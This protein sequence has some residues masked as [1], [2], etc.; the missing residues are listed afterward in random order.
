MEKRSLK[1]RKNCSN[2]IG[3]FFAL[4][5]SGLWENSVRLSAFGK[6]DYTEVLSL[7]EGQSVVGLVMAGL[8]HVNDVTVPQV[9][10]LLFIGKSVNIEQQ[11]EAM[12]QFVW[13]LVVKMRKADIYTVLVKGQGIAQCYERPLWRACG[14]VYFLLSEDNYEKAKHILLPIATNVGKEYEYNQ[15]QALTTGAYTVEL[16]GNMRCGLSGR[17]DAVIDEVQR[18]VFFGGNVRSWDNGKTYVFLPGIDC[19]VIFVFTHFLKHFYKGGLGLRQICDWCRLLW[20]YREAINR[21]LLESRLREMRLVS[22]WKAFGAFAVEYLGMPVE[23]M[24]L[25]DA[26]KRWKQKAKRIEDFVMMSG[27]F[28]HNRD[29]SYWT[30]YSYLIRKAFSMKRRVGDLI[31]HASIFPMDSL[32]F[33]PSIVGHGFRSA[34]MGE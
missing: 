31:N 17:M 7:A 27:N 3:A 29:S 9:E 16:H 34:I 1:N 23:A 11:N 4:L 13:E 8:E 22:E 10:R 5:S 30:K 28:G 12:N 26:S 19:D 18:D 32:R 20:T 21:S 15:H 2:N 25:F 24:P 6:I 14:D 33:F